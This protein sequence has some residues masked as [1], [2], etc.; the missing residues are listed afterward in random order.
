MAG[1]THV[2]RF[3]GAAIAVAVWALLVFSPRQGGLTPDYV[4]TFTVLLGGLAAVDLTAPRADA[5]L[6]RRLLW[7]GAELGL[8]YLVVREHGT[9]VRPTFAYLVPATR[10]LLMFGE[11]A[12]VALS[13]SVWAAYTVNIW[14]FAGFGHP[15]EYR[16]Y[17]LYLLA[18]YVVAVLLTWGM[19]RQARDREHIEALYTDLRAA[20]DELQALHRQVR[21]QAVA[22]ERSR[23]AREIHD[24]LA[25]YLTV[26][27]VQ[28]EAAEKL[29][30][31]KPSLE[32]LHRARRLT[33][34]CLQ[35]VRQ[36]VAALRASSLDELSLPRA[37]RRLAKEFTRNTGIPVTLSLTLSDDKRLA[38]ETS[39]TLYRVAQEGLT[40]VHR[41]ARAAH[42]ALTLEQHNSQIEVAVRDDGAGPPNQPET[43]GF[44]LL[45]LRERVAL[46]G[47]QLTF[48]RV[49]SGGS[50]LAVV[51][52]VVGDR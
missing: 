12:G 11:R 29:H 48:E 20:H 40:N 44:G 2:L 46:L 6:L 22:E 8:A 35:E 25:H 4:L 10:A 28:L 50:R 17:L 37:L 52:P 32:Q 26:I 45:G 47:G 51:L 3:G 21:E 16:T 30:P 27:N 41:H 14:D 5:P 7:L 49:S 23:L 9:F 18:P 42:A 19:L 38:P 36:S 39:L 33:L 34:E 31:A 24:S 43:D 15:Q 1:G 13:L